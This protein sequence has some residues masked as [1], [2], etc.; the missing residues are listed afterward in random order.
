M[1]SKKVTYTEL[2]FIFLHF[3]HFKAQMKAEE[4]A[5]QKREAEEKEAQQEKRREERRLQKQVPKHPSCLPHLTG[6]V[7]RS[8]YLLTLRQQ[9]GL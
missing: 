2:N 5:R 1:F 4:E 9:P 3:L 7:K 6:I 8:R